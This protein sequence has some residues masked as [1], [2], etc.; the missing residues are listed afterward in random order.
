MTPVQQEAQRKHMEATAE[1]HE[2]M[3]NYAAAKTTLYKAEA[4]MNAVRNKLAV[5]QADVMRA[6]SA[7]AMEP[8]KSLEQA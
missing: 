6:L 5:A 2:A 7:G 3:A 8:F 1:W 4:D